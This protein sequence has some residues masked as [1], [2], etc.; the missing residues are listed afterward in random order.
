[1]TKPK[2]FA[3]IFSPVVTLLA[4][5]NP[6]LA[7]T[8]GEGYCTVGWH[9]LFLSNNEVCFEQNESEGFAI[10]SQLCPNMTVTEWT[11][12]WATPNG[13]VAQG[14]RFANP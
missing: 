9:S 8:E 14:C 2:L 10:C 11:A 3:V 4:T 6:A 12:C 13:G 1:M 7:E 5:A